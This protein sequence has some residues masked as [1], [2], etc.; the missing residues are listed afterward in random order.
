MTAILEQYWLNYCY[1][2]VTDCSIRISQS[3]NG[4]VQCAAVKASLLPQN[5]S[6]ILD[7]FTYLFCSKLCWHNRLMPME[8]I[9]DK[10]SNTCKDCSVFN[11]K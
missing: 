6:I 4:F 7:S 2:R 3:F 11:L 1:I 9:T 10:V 8:N 5:A